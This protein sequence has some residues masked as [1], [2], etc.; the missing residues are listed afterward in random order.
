VTVSEFGLRSY[1][2]RDACVV[3][4]RGDVD[5]DAAGE[6][7][8]TLARLQRDATVFVDLWDVTAMDPVCLGILSTAKA[9]TD[10]TRWEFAIVAEP[11]GVAAQEIEAAGLEGTLTPFATKQ[12]ARA[13]LLRGP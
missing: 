4:V 12:D 2:W 7:S 1:E 10:E 9:R 8:R 6:L 3:V 11:G 5:L 13:A